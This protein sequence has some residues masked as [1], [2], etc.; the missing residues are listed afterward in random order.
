MRISTQTIARSTF[1]CAVLV[2]P[3]SACE[4]EA[5]DKVPDEVRRL[6]SEAGSEDVDQRRDAAAQVAILLLK[7]NGAWRKEPFNWKIR[8]ERGIRMEVK[9][10][11]SSD[12]RPDLALAN[13]CAHCMGMLASGTWLKPPTDTVDLVESLVIGLLNKTS[14]PVVKTILL[15]GLGSS[16]TGAARDAVV[17]ATG[18]PD[19]GVQKGACYL[20]ERCAANYFGPVGNI[21]IGS[22][23]ASVNAAGK[24][25]RSI[26]RW[27]RTLGEG[28]GPMCNGLQARLELER[29]LARVGQ[30]I[31]AK[32]VVRNVSDGTITIAPDHHPKQYLT[33]LRD[34][35]RIRLKLERVPAPLP[36]VEVAPGK[37]ITYWSFCLND[38]L[39]ITEEG[40]YRVWVGTTTTVPPRSN[41]VHLELTAND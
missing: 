37:P 4:A 32:L 38:G 39:D 31:E 26:Y 10:V 34:K 40:K 21:G 6:L 22:T 36:P 33:G 30:R 5:A 24:K 18:D 27:D 1:I 15:V 12:Q 19:P 11:R 13:M 23:E 14:D 29:T 8:T 35:E 28:W 7:R 16:K 3:L 41:T 25:I 20:V 9:A 17:S 2:A